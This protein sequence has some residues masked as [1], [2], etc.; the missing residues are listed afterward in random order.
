MCQALFKHLCVFSVAKLR[1]TLCYPRT[2][3]HQT[4]LSMGFPMQEYWSML[5]FSSPGDLPDPGIKH[6]SPAWQ[7]DFFYH[8]TPP[9]SP[10]KHLRDIVIKQ[11]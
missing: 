8:C 1:Q 3:A 9:G 7:A 6:R 2:I 10:F 5:P 11:G 4:P